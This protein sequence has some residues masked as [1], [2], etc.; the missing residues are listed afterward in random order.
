MS[1][2]LP[3]LAPQID[4]M[5][6]AAAARAEELASAIP[7]LLR[8]LETVASLDPESLQ[9]KVQRAGDR[10]SGAAP[11][12]EGID[13]T[14]APPSL[15]KGTR[16]IA[17][18]GSQIYPNR[19]AAALHYLINIG[20]I[21]IIYDQ[22]VEPQTHVSPKLFFE[23]ADLYNEEEG[24]ISNALVDGERDTLEMAY[25]AQL[26]AGSGSQRTL[27]LLDGSLLLWLALRT[28][29]HPRRDV[30][31]ILARYLSQLDRLRASGAAIA[32]VVD[33]PR[34]A[35]VLALL[36]IGA[37]DVQAIT[38]E[39]AR[40]RA[41]PW[42][43]DRAVFAR[44]LPAGHRSARFVHAS[45]VHRDFRNHGHEVQFFY[46]NDPDT[47]RIARVEVPGWV[48]KDS[49]LL[50]LVHAGILQQSRSTGGYPYALIRAHE[51]AVVTHEERRALQAMVETALL[52]AGLIPERSQKARTKDWLR[53]RRRH[54]V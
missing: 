19:H 54:R 5:G 50:D 18:D 43:P 39:N 49:S 1:L 34:S 12:E 29:N 6:Q 17:A 42:L 28:Q 9:E 22:G 38:P 14:Y 27:A 35:N 11:T 8:Q 13:T 21:E 44:H 52:R 37:L 41:H 31:R 20:A 2:H 51:L 15:S 33:R 48:G 7:S 36:H 32:G 45:P 3:Q 24:L 10:W 30:D 4:Q 25:L 47:G 16:V 53:G 23:D 46:L 26:A 40:A